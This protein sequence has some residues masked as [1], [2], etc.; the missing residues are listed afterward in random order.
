MEERLIAPIYRMRGR[1]NGAKKIN[2]EEE[3][4]KEKE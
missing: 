4:E 2:K 3:A 1:M